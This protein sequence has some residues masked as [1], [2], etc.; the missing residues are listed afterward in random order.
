MRFFLK[1]LVSA[2]TL[3]VSVLPLS[4][5]S[6]KW[7][8][9]FGGIGDDTDIEVATDQW[10]NVFVMG[11]YTSPVLIFGSNSLPN[12]G[13][14]EVF[15][16]KFDSSGNFL[17]ATHSNGAG[18][19]YGSD[20]A[21][22]PSG[23]V[24]VTGNFSSDAVT[25]GTF[26]LLNSSTGWGSEQDAFVVKYDPAGNVLWAIA[27]EGEDSESGSGVATDPSGNVIVS[28][29]FDSDTI[30]F[31]TAVFK[32]L[33]PVFVLKL[34]PAGNLV[35]FNNGR[36]DY[37]L[38][39]LPLA[40]DAAGNVFMSGSFFGGQVG[41]G[42]VWVANQAS[43][44]SEIFLFKM[45]PSG[46]VTEGK[47]IGGSVDDNGMDLAVDNL[48]NV[49]LI[50]DFI[51]PLLQFETDTLHLP[52]GRAAFWAK[53]DND[54][55]L[56]WARCTEGFG[57]VYGSS[58]ATDLSGNIFSTGTLYSG[59]LEL[60]TFVHTVG[61]GPSDNWLA[62]LDPAGNLIWAKAI[63]GSD[64][65]EA[66]GVA[67]DPLGNVY[68]SGQFASPSIDF[69]D[70]T[71]NHRKVWDL[72][73]AKSDGGGSSLFHWPDDEDQWIIYPNPT[74]AMLLFKTQH[75]L[76]DATIFVHNSMGQVVLQMPSVNMKSGEILG[77]DLSSLTDGL[78]Y[79][80]LH[81]E[82]QELSTQ[83]VQVGD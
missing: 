79:V 57:Q 24:I 41:L 7:A 45:D 68:A 80:S 59:S 27:S 74:R 25:F 36:G 31:G 75:D 50:G 39:E 1:L 55:N 11:N 33:G 3:F 28:G 15:L 70:T 77:L 17:W 43:T 5:Q 22:D 63:G 37:N 19:E 52:G 61:S 40:T 4:A 62:K 54:L 29:Y 20:M 35:W 81:Q 16:A 48:G 18:D 60:D 72:F 14:A 23:N 76:Q 13:G 64:Y 67:C 2:L 82:G 46:N 34:D 83:K 42:S 78:Y 56:M 38:E 58:V 10:G 32:R 9:A 12:P 8:A 65:E 66:E 51:S 69:G 44:Y 6:W 53:F 71:L 49:I 73:I 26:T 47:S 30:Q 21:V